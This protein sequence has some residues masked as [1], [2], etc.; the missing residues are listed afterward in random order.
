MSKYKETL[1][2]VGISGAGN[3]IEVWAN[4]ETGTF[5]IISTSP[6][7]VSCFKVGGKGFLLSVP[8][9]KGTLN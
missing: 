5:T 8:E 9:P 3:L 7:G 2:S 6:R 4:L 1:Q